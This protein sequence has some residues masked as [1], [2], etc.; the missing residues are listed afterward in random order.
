MPNWLEDDE[1]RWRFQF[2]HFYSIWERQNW[3][4]EW[5]LHNRFNPVQN[6]LLD[7][8]NGEALIEDWAGV[9]ER[10]QGAL[11][12]VQ[13][14]LDTFQH[15]GGRPNPRRARLIGD[16]LELRRRLFDIHQQ[17]QITR[18]D[19]LN[20]QDLAILVGTAMEGEWG[21]EADEINRLDE[22]GFFDTEVVLEAMD[23]GED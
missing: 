6:E 8:A 23:E 13:E 14:D 10:I 9:R 2:E 21:D 12:M 3:R 18:Q 11:M 19:L 1:G 5:N 15:W 22:E 17:E 16:I 4:L 7:A 20:L